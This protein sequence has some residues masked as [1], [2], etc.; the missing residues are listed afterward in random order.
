MRVY[1]SGALQASSDLPAARARYEHAAR[2]I[3]ERGHFPYLPHKHTDPVEAASLS[4]EA[5]FK[6][7]RQQ[8]SECDAVVAFIDE[9]SLGVGCELALAHQENA[10]ILALRNE[11]S[12]VSRFALG[13]LEAIGAS[14][15]TYR[16]VDDITNAIGSFV[17]R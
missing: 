5:V 12:S 1:I 8:L 2:V 16:S 15:Q 7:D 6:R 4:A 17:K 14:V 3:E 10:R 13:F 9:P 11:A